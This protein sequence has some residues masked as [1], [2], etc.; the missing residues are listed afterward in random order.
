[1]REQDDPPCAKLDKCVCKCRSKCLICGAVFNNEDASLQDHLRSVQHQ[2]MEQVQGEVRVMG[3]ALAFG[4]Q[5]HRQS[6]VDSYMLTYFVVKEKLP[7]ATP[8]KLKKMLPFLYFC[9]GDSIK[10]VALSRET[11]ARY[12]PPPSPSRSLYF[13]YFALC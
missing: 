6:T 7:M 11:I 13:S 3:Q 10:H 8:D 4:G 2:Q 12:Y 5:Q 1:M 9:D